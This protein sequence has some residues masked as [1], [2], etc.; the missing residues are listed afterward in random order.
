L[1]RA[2]VVGRQDAHACYRGVGGQIEHLGD[3]KIEQLGFAF[4]GDQNVLGLQIAVYYQIAVQV[5]DGRRH[6]EKKPDPL[7]DLEPGR[8]EVDWFPFDVLH[9]QI[10]L[11]ILTMTRVQ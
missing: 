1:F 9:Y 8:I 4:L 10:W 2:R 6:F 3:T 11:A 7:P 5:R